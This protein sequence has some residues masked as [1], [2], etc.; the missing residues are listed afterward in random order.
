MPTTPSALFEDD[1]LAGDVEAALRGSTELRDLQRA[2]ETLR[3][4][5]DRLLAKL[6]FI[7]EDP[8]LLEALA[9]RSYR[10]QNGFTKVKLVAKNRYSV[11]LHLWTPSAT[12]RGDVDPHA[13]RWAF[14]SWVVCGAGIRERFYERSAGFGPAAGPYHRYLF[15]ADTADAWYVEPVERTWLTETQSLDR[16]KGTV[17]VCPLGTVHTV[18]P[19]GGGFAATVVV[20]GP[21]ITGPVPVYTLVGSYPRAYERPISAAELHTDLRAFEGALGQLIEAE[22]LSPA[23]KPESVNLFEARPIGIY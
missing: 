14:A 9:G 17:Y 4:H 3:S 18:S 15:G 13:H 23:A 8:D 20:Q 12:P 19:L 11:R 21:H 22:T 1:E 6:R 2:A 5:P 16:P 7:R 10:H